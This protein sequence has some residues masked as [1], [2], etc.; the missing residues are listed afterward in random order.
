[1]EGHSLAALPSSDGKR[2][3][4]DEGVEVKRRR[5][6]HDEGRLIRV[7]H[8]LELT[9]M[10]YMDSTDDAPSSVGILV[11][12]ETI[13]AITVDGNLA[14]EDVR[15]LSHTFVEIDSQAHNGKHRIQV[16]GAV[17][18]VTRGILMLA[19]LLQEVLPT[20]QITLVVLIPADAVGPIIG[21]GG[22][23]LKTIREASM[24]QL[25]VERDNDPVFN[26]RRIS[27]RGD[28]AIKVACA[29]YRI[30]RTPK[31]MELTDVTNQPRGNPPPLPVIPGEPSPY[32]Q[33]QAPSPVGHALSS[34]H[35]HSLFQGGSPH[36]DPYAHH[37]APP[38]HHQSP[39]PVAHHP[40]HHIA[41]APATAPV[42]HHQPPTAHHMVGHSLSAAMPHPHVP[43][44]VAPGVPG[45]GLPPPATHGAQVFEN[46]TCFIHYIQINFTS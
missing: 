20:E 24:T 4:P 8:E 37:Q 12:E 38:A 43:Y 29:L 5:L 45:T 33:Y 2:G 18:C 11:P 22:S 42:A 19:R 44:G 31:F 26:Q 3:A 14:I 25:D 13:P 34:P 9:G 40:A 28:A 46:K 17:A 23:G 32:P 35:G 6:V 36:A 1:M 41:G 10:F 16:F 7:V 21:K 39:P 27:V 30:L 15:R